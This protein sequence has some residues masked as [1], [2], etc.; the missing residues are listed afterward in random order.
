MTYGDAGPGSDMGE[1]GAFML[2]GMGVSDGLEL[3]L[4]GI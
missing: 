4:A 3:L 1:R 2:R